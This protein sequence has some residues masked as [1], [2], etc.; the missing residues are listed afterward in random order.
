MQLSTVTGQLSACLETVEK[1]LPV[2]TTVPVIN[3]ILLNIDSN[4]LTFS[5]TNHEIFINV[6]MDHQG[7]D[8]GRILLPPKIV[9]IVRYFPTPSVL[10]DINWDNYRL[11][12]SGG[13]A[14][15]HLYGASAED[16]PTTYVSPEEELTE[17]FNLDLI[18]FKKILKEVV[19]AASTEETRPAFNGILFTFK[20]QTLS[21]TASDT[22][23]LVINE[24]YDQSW[25]FE[26]TKCLVPAKALREFL[27]IAGEGHTGVTVGYQNSLL[28]VN[29]DNT[30]FAS[31]LL[32]EKYP[33]VS[34][35][36]PFEFKTRVI[37]ERKLLE[38]TIARAALLAEGKNQAVNIAVKDNRF[39]VRVNS[40]EGSMEEYLPVEQEGEG[41]ELFVNSRF[42]LDILKI[43]DEEKII[44]DFHGEGGPLIFR[45]LDNSSY[46]YLVL[47]IKKVN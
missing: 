25:S 47:P 7:S 34:G 13:S 9:D 15:F 32:E 17:S 4:R 12:I 27:R 29:F 14:R 11:D 35:V 20:G 24:I 8:S 2:R 44:I 1:A 36:I 10:I 46:L 6:S 23:R 19:F 38:E 5:A 21:L 3:N 45:L 26:E 40:Q 16:F 30:F 33:D 18:R 28:T 39:E 43:R 31:R 37:I 41:L 42:I 22:Y